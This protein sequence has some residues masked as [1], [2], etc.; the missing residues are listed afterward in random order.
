LSKAI[1]RAANVFLER[2]LFRRRSNGAVIRSEFLELH[3]PLYW[4]YD[5]LGGLKVLAEG[6]LLS[7]PRA[8]EA[9]D[10]LAK[11]RLDDGGF[12][13]EKRYYKQST[14]LAPNA[15]VVDWGG[16]SKRVSNPWVTADALSVLR[17]AGRT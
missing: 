7:D 13:A 15:D 8:T 6:G 1:Q 4:H 16:T 3:Y 17:A 10:E 5:I 9:L 11:K 2:R 14:K 12:P